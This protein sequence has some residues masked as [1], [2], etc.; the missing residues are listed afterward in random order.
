MH[1]CVCVCAKCLTW[2]MCAVL[3]N[4]GIQRAGVIAL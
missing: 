4:V 2:A 1:V 3:V